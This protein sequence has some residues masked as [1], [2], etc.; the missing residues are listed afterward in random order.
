M[1]RRPS[2]GGYIV[3]AQQA[4]TAVVISISKCNSLCLGASLLGLM[5]VSSA[6]AATAVPAKTVPI[7]GRPYAI[8]QPTGQLRYVPPRAVA[9]RLIVKLRPHVRPA[10]LQPL[11][12]ETNCRIARALPVSGMV[13]VDL[14]RGSDLHAAATELATRP[15]VEFAVPDTFVYP[16][17][18]PNDPKYSHQYHLPLIDAP[19]AWEVT[20]G[21]SSV[22]IAIIDSG[23]DLDHPDLAAKIWTNPGEVPGNGI[24]DDGNGFIDDVHGWDFVHDDNDP[25]P[26][27]DGQD[28]DSNG[29]V[30]EQVSHGTLAAGLAAAVTND[31]W[32]S[33]G[34]DWSA[35]I[36][37]IQVFDDDGGSPVSRV[38]E[39]IDYAT[40]MGV[41][42]I[43]LSLGGGYSQAFSPPINRAYE[44]G[45][46]VVSAAGNS[47]TEFTN[48]QSTWESPVCNDGPDVFSDNYVLGITATDRYDQRANYANFD[49]STANFVDVA[50]PGQAVYGPMFYDP[51]WPMFDEYWGTN[52]GTSFSC[53]IVSGLAALLIAQYPTITPAQVYQS[54]RNTTDNIDEANPGYAGKLGT[55]RVNAARALGVASAPRPVAELSAQDTP[56]DQGGSITITWLKSPD[57]GAGADSVTSYIIR[58]APNASGPFEDIAQLP[59]GTEQYSDE[60]VTDGTDYYYLIRTSDGTLFSDSQITGPVQSRDDCPP[61]QITT[62]GAVDRPDDDGGAVVLTWTYSPPSDFA[63]YRIYRRTRDF[64]NV[65]GLT[66]MVAIDQSTV[67][68]Y[69]DD[70][71]L[72]GVDYYYAITAVDV[73]G[74]EEL[75]VQTAGPV[76]SYPNGELTFPAGL[77]MLGTPAVPIDEHPATLFGL[78]PAE[79]QYARWDTTNNQ[80]VYYQGEPLPQFLQLALGSGFWIDLP[81]QVNV[82]PEGTSAPAGDFDVPVQPGWHQLA[83]PFFG[84]IDFGA[85]TVTYESNTM[86]LLSADIQGIARSVAW[87]YEDDSHSYRMINAD[88]AGSRLVSP[89]QGFWML[90]LKNCTVTIPRPSAPAQLP[91]PAQAAVTTTESDNG[92]ALRLVAE[93]GQFRD[94]DNFCGV[95]PA[96][97][98]TCVDNPPTVAGGVDLYFSPSASN[99][100]LAASFRRQDKPQL[101]WE[102]TVTWQQPFAEIIISWPTVDQI[103]SRYTAT[104]CDRESAKTVNLRT[105][106]CYRFTAGQPGQRHFRLEFHRT[107]N[108]P[109]MV[110]NVTALSHHGRGQITFILSKSAN[111]DIKIMNIAGRPIRVLQT[112]RTYPAG[113]SIVAWDGRS[114]NGSVVPNGRYLIEI[115]AA[116]PDGTAARG[117][118]AMNIVR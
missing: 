101:I 93:A 51:A 6:V 94:M 37:P 79:L 88:T 48:A 75:F 60:T 2:A 41:D 52:S 17:R 84:A 29:S 114:G 74:N 59:A 9:D 27:P 71:T 21:S 92:W 26:Q 46:V 109:L 22:V 3:N 1:H 91:H 24:D 102:M 80:Y 57:D 86:D 66:A 25:T 58:R 4:E 32:G 45:I 8:V 113:Q 7:P 61:P 82:Q 89:W 14:P 10:Q 110:T 83:N 97:A 96:A 106:H 20:V 76:Q 104:L 72:D 36:L 98:V 23:C 115:R 15:E 54:I 116:A 70:T 39:A 49:S 53:P 68:Q 56:G 105:Q 64:N 90:V 63:A 87:V 19:Q 78:D 13:V 5:V 85:C 55:G 16:A 47:D 117:L 69:I 12:A 50:A 31:G 107:G 34:M 28:D 103:P 18:I 95:R 118:A 40:Q 43:N 67:A 99:R 42:I 62:L 44:A 100:R 11:A 33:A 108:Q 65:D 73:V 30:D 81:H 77:A 111:C 112:G 35:K 38:C